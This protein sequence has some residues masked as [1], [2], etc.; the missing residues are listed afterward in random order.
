MTK[1]IHPLR[2]ARRVFGDIRENPKS[3]MGF[4][5]GKKKKKKKKKKAHDSLDWMVFESSH[6]FVCDG[7]LREGKK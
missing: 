5:V 2:V 7:R 3:K 6:M 4:D 1:L